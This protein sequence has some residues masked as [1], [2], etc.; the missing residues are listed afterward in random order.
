MDGTALQ[1]IADRVATGLPAATKGQ[2]FGEGTDVYKVVDKVF[3]IVSERNGSAMVTLKA[4]PPHVV[5]LLAGHPSITPGYHMNKRHWVTIGPGADV[6]ERLVEDL[7]GNS[8]DLIVSTLPRD[9][10]PIDP[11]RDEPDQDVR[12]MEPLVRPRPGPVSSPPRCA[13]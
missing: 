4:A 5:A 9:R 7:V 2:P 12:A 10:R 3:V 1:R 8:Y 11:V 6:T 13:V